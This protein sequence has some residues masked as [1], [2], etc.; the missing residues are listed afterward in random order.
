MLPAFPEALSR[1][2]V[3]L[4]PLPAFPPA[5]APA[6]LPPLSSLDCDRSQLTPLLLW[7][8]E[9]SLEKGQLA[10]FPLAYPEPGLPGLWS[11]S[12]LCW[13]RGQ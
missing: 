11:G 12:A 3:C 10:A 4:F 6:S 7:Q 2:D 1:G 8:P 9:N 5:G 13:P